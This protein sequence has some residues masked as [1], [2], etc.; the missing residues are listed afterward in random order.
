MRGMEQKA[1]D[2]VTTEPFFHIIGDVAR[3][4]DERT[5]PPSRGEALVDLS[6]RQ[7]FLPRPAEDVAGIA[8]AAECELPFRYVGKRTI[9]IVFR[10]IEP[11]ELVRQQFEPDV[12]V[13]HGLQKMVQFLRLFAGPS[14]DRIETRHYSQRFRRA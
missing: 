10:K 9:E 14:D 4:A 13:D 5:L 3:R 2:A 8:E 1:V 6:D 7:P 11:A 12:G